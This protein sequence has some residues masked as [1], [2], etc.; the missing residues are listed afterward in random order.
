MCRGLMRPEGVEQCRGKGLVIVH[1]CV[2]CGFVR[3]NKIADDPAQA[4][5]IDAVIA[6]MNTAFGAGG[7]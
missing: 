5:D 2:A 3:I 7:S 6:V 1:R 4:D